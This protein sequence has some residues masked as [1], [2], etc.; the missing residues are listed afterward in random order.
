[1]EACFSKMLALTY[2]TTWCHNQEDHNLKNHHHEN[3]KTYI[4]KYLWI[5]QMSQ[6]ADKNEWIQGHSILR[7]DNCQ[8]TFYAIF[9]KEYYLLGCN[10]VWSCWN[11]PAFHR[12]ILAPAELCLLPASYWLLAWLTLWHWIWRK[13]VPPKQ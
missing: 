3:L 7:G 5:W 2:K 8:I 4:W 12:S 10:A 9:I 1:M 13:Y 11:S 6:K